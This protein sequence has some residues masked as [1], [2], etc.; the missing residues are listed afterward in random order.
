MD[1]WIDRDG[2]IVPTLPGWQTLKVKV[3]N[4]GKPNYNCF[5]NQELKTSLPQYKSKYSLVFFFQF[6]CWNKKDDI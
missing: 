4:P 5:I 2:W 1:V 6:L 3:V